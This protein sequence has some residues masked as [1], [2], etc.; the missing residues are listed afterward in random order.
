MLV[1]G[2]EADA[3]L[4]FGA[5]ADAVLVFGAEADAV[6][7]FGAGL[8]AVLVFFPQREARLGVSRDVDAVLVL[9]G[10][11]GPPAK[12]E[13]EV[14]AGVG[15]APGA[16]PRTELD[17]PPR[18]ISILAGSIRNRF[19]ANARR[20]AGQS[21]STN[22]RLNE[23]KNEDAE[24]AMSSAVGVSPDSGSAGA[25]GVSDATSSPSSLWSLSGREARVLMT[26]LEIYLQKYGKY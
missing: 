11:D 16:L 15:R 21:W 23:V 17:P 18:P 6:L 3:V 7:V 26:W 13:V 12:R 4:V 19:I 10:A 8:D 22:A 24:V 20:G 9:A 2:A 25:L 5:E 1:F 14:A